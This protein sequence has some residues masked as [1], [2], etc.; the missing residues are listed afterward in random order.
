RLSRKVQQRNMNIENRT[1]RISGTIYII[2]GGLDMDTEIPAWAIQAA[3]E[4]MGY[5]DES[6]V[7]WEDYPLVMAM[8]ESMEGE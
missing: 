1:K 5:A 6:E 3:C 2:R 7:A 8:A 4:A